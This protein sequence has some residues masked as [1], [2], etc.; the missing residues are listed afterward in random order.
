MAR[1]Y[2]V[3]AACDLSCKHCTRSTLTH[4][5]AASHAAPCGC[6]L[7]EE[8]RERERANVSGQ[9]VQPCQL[10]VRFINANLKCRDTNFRHAAQRQE[11][12]HDLQISLIV[13]KLYNCV[14]MIW[15]CCVRSSM[16][17]VDAVATPQRRKGERESKGAGLHAQKIKTSIS[18]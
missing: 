11:C 3:Y 6:H 7:R 4:M 15:Q 18:K 9:A 8:E 1:V 5:A 13:S 10:F 2:R 12:I 14:E 16:L 17:T